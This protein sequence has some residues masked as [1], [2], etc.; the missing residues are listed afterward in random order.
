M[1]A[2]VPLAATAGVAVVLGPVT[3]AAALAAIAVAALVLAGRRVPTVFHIALAGLLLGYMFLGRGFAYIGTGSIFIGEAGVALA[4][5]ATLVAG[6][7]WR[8]GVV[9]ALL[10]AFIGWGAIRT[11]PYVGTYGP[12]AL[13]DAVS[14]GYALIAI[15][16]A[17]TATAP[18]ILGSVRLFRRVALLAVIWF[19]VAAVLTIV[20]GDQIPSAPGSEVPLIFFKGGDAGVHLA[21]IAAFVFAG[22]YGQGALREAFL[23]TAWAT[24]GVLVAALNRGGMVAATTSVLALLFVRRISSLLVL[25]AVAVIL[26]AGAFVLNPRVDLGIQ[27]NISFQQLVDNVTSIVIDRPNTVQ[28][29][30]KEWRLE[31]WSAIVDYTVD[32]PYFWTGKGYGVNL[33]D[34]DGFQVNADRSLRAP[35]SAHFEFL[36]RSGVPGLVLWLVLQAAWAVSMV[37]AAVRARRTGRPWWLAIIAWL[38]VYWLAALVNMSVDVYL[39][40]PQGGIWF[41]TIFGAGIVVSRLTHQG[42]PDAGDDVR[43]APIPAT[44]T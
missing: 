36:A 20:Y 28:Q 38:F 7:R 16:I 12:L 24:S 9:E 19:P 10:L 4:V 25:I 34:S 18:T 44:P 35:H 6:G 41:W 22:L 13:R 37:T 3:T 43:V 40:G 23:W 17:A 15:G 11:I 21:G 14:W 32:G 39:G 33:A 26:V 27:R 8:V 42:T 1:A 5:A 2:A 31:W 30:T 29:G